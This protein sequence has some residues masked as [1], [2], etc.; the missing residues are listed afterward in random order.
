MTDIDPDCVITEEHLGDLAERAGGMKALLCLSG[1]E[2]AKV[3]QPEDD[4]DEAE[5]PVDATLHYNRD[6][7]DQAFDDDPADVRHRLQAPVR[8]SADYDADEIDDQA[9]AQQQLS[10]PGRPHARW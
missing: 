6:Q 5:L 1:P 8:P 10:A 7:I 3:M 9:G 2:L 4:V